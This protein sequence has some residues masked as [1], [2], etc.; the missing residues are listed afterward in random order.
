MEFHRKRS[1]TLI[2]LMYI[3]VNSLLR[4]IVTHSTNSILPDYGMLSSDSVWYQGV[5]IDTSSK[6][7][8]LPW[9]RRKTLAVALSRGSITEVRESLWKHSYAETSSRR[10]DVERAL[11]LREKKDISRAEQYLA[12]QSYSEEFAQHILLTLRA[13]LW[14]EQSQWSQ[15]LDLA[16]D[17]EKLYPLSAYPLLVQWWAFRMQR[18]FLDAKRVF[19]KASLLSPSMEDWSRLHRGVTLF[20]TRD[21]TGAIA[22]LSWLQYHPFYGDEATIFLARVYFEQQDYESAR[23]LFAS[24]ESSTWYNIQAYMWQ[25]RIETLLANY[26]WAMVLYQQ[27]FSQNSWNIEYITDMLPVAHTLGVAQQRDG[28][29]RMIESN[30]PS[31]IQPYELIIRAYRKLWYY[32][33]AKRRFLSW[34][35]LISDQERDYLASVDTLTPEHEE[36]LL[37]FFQQ[38]NMLKREYHTVL[39]KQSL[40]L[41]QSKLTEWRKERAEKLFTAIEVLWVNQQDL[42]MLQWIYAFLSGDVL[43]ARN[44]LQQL[45]MLQTVEA[46]DLLLANYFIVVEENI[47]R[48]KTLLLHEYTGDLHRAHLWVQYLIA[49]YLGDV[50]QTAPLI[51]QLQ[52]EWLLSSYKDVSSMPI[53]VQKS[54]AIRALDPYTKRFSSYLE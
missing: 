54:I 8:I 30:S 9:N 24:L 20:Y 3:V 2:V 15:C 10:H 26:T 51:T 13:Q 25:W 31:Y 27:W 52:Q 21:F 46:Q 18:K 48:A 35:T 47:P 28:L 40:D 1:Y 39:V 23:P 6:K 4:Y 12:Q 14:C 45:P 42:F 29:I 41:L 16:Q 38:R 19:E 50:S 43:T 7:R 11:V 5:I 37:Q 32:N 36:R 17:A 33:D 34:L 44:A 53:T 49:L 22:D